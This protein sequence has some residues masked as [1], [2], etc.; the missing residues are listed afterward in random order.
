MTDPEDRTGDYDE[1]H[2]AFEFSE[3]HSVAGAC[4][5]ADGRRQTVSSSRGSS[6]TQAHSAIGVRQKVVVR[7]ASSA[8]GTR[9]Q[10]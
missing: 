4:G 1:G 8:M 5:G 10:V 9:Q 6:E 7:Q 2:E 3:E